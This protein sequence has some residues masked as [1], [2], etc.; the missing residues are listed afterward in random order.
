MATGLL[1]W[2][3]SW[4]WISFEEDE[5]L[6]WIRD[7]LF[8]IIEEVDAE[9]G[10]NSLLLVAAAARLLRLILSCKLSDRVKFKEGLLAIILFEDDALRSGFE[11]S[12]SASVISSSVFSS[13][14]VLLI[15]FLACES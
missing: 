7:F 8:G 5:D 12:A 1:L 13:P 6:I 4:F 3:A 9:R 15:S 10:Q 11:K 14:A 2:F